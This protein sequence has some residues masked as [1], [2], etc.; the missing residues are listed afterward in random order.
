MK[1]VLLTIMLTLLMCTGC[2]T[3]PMKFENQQVEHEAKM[4]REE[5]KQNNIEA[6]DQRFQRILQ[7]TGCWKSV[8]G[9]TT[10]EATDETLGIALFRM[11]N[12][13]TFRL[14]R[15]V[16][17]AI[18]GY[19]GLSGTQTAVGGGLLLTLLTIA[20]TFAKKY[21][22]QTKKTQEA[23]QKVE[24]SEKVQYA[25]ASAIE[26]GS[27]KDPIIGDLIKDEVR[28]QLLSG[29]R[30]HEIVQQATTDLRAEMGSRIAVAEIAEKPD[31]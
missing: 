29:T 6:A 18:G 16:M 5:L 3:A 2:V 17:G 22:S 13:T 1:A 25:Q 9:K 20:G 19:L 8:Y 23:E 7:L 26:L 30:Q 14:G 4:G 15:M 12:D 21:L 28:S 10:E 27:I 24:A 11:Q 31:D